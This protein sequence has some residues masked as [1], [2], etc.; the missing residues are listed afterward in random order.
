MPRATTLLLLS[1]LALVPISAQE[2]HGH[3]RDNGRDKG[4]EREHHEAAVRSFR[5]GDRAAIAEYYRSRRH[6]A[7]LP[8]GLE[9]QL[10]RNGTLPPGLAKRFVPF[11]PELDRRLPPCPVGMRRGLIGGVA[12]MWNPRT[13]LIVDATALFGR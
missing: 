6:G 12:V 2:G 13:G 3:G 10:R 8:P 1:V 5:P 9:R 7:P 11:P 4:H